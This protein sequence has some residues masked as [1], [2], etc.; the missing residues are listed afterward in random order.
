MHN[1]SSMINQ[2]EVIHFSP[3]LISL[4]GLT[5]PRVSEQFSRHDVLNYSTSRIH[6]QGSS[7]TTPLR[8]DENLLILFN[9]YSIIGVKKYHQIDLV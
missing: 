2:V 9:S 5:F 4:L 1:V 8:K 6:I 7:F 3:Q